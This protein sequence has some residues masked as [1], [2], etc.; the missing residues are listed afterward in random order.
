MV[1][2]SKGNPERLQGGEKVG[3]T[4]VN[5]IFLKILFEKQGLMDR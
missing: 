2:Y 5:I 4:N 3:L 1:L